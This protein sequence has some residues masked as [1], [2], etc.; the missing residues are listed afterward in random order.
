M[1]EGIYQGCRLVSKLIKMTGFDG[2][3]LL[4]TIPHGIPHFHPKNY[5]VCWGL[6][7]KVCKWASSTRLVIDQIGKCFFVGSSPIFFTV[8]DSAG[9]EDYDRI[10][11]M[12][13][14]HTDVFIICYRYLAFHIFCISSGERISDTFG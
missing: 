11:P 1:R 2:I 3:L 13:Y 5:D 6:Q 4:Y 7:R 9:Q 10:R 8:W 12:S 14:T